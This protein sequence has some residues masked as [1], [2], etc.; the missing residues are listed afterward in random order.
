[1]KKQKICIVGDGLTA[2]TTSLILSGLDIKIDLIF[3]RKKKEKYKDNRSIAL[4][5]SNYS[6]L[7]QYLTKRDLNFFWPCKRID[8]YRENL[9][10]YNHFMNFENKGKCIMRIIE[11]EKLKKIILKKIRSNKNIKVINTELKKFNPKKSL[12]FIKNKKIDYDLIILCVGR[13]SDLISKLVGKRYIKEDTKEIA[14][15]SLVTHNSKII[16]PKQ[17]FLKEGPLAILP[18]NKKT[19][20]FVWSINKKYKNLHNNSV[21]D[22]LGVKL[23]KFFGEKNNFVIK[24]PVCFPISFE[25]NTNFFNKNSLLLGNAWYSVHPIAGQGFNLIFRDI[26]ELYEEINRYIFSGIQLKDSLI[27]KQFI[28]SRKPENLLF[29]I[30]IN[31]TSKFF[32]YNKSNNFFK[33]IILKDINKFKFLKDLSLKISNTGILK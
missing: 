11:N 7:S 1:M 14:F 27:L 16:E 31:I 33:D 18:I 8:L 9:G 3:K 15:T 30:G 25:F 5:E 32:K 24:K 13:K 10:S 23:K 29:G 20:S 21:K 19:F 22:L 17:Y 4:S 26:K 12:V 28:S 6:F 2:L